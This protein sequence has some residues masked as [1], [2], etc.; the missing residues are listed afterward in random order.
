MNVNV[1]LESISVQR[2]IKS[3]STSKRLLIALMRTSSYKTEWYVTLVFLRFSTC[4]VNTAC[5]QL[6]LSSNLRKC[7]VWFILLLF[8]MNLFRMGSKPTW[9]SSIVIKK[10]SVIVP[11]SSFLKLIL[12]AYICISFDFSALINASLLSPFKRAWYL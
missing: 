9:Y 3:I 10:Y 11:I 6:L 8:S 2:K 1:T 12:S 4:S 5:C 7:S